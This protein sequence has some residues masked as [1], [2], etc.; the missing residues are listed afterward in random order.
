MGILPGPGQTSF[1]N[2][3]GGRGGEQDREQR[4]MQARTPGELGELG[5]PAGSEDGR[6]PAARDPTKR[7]GAPAR[8]RD[9]GTRLPGE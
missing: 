8:A 9:R 1:N 6:S 3:G 7:G 2:R 5:E 4:T